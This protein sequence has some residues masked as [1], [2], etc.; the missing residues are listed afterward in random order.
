MVL[1][2]VVFEC[3]EYLWNVSYYR[4]EEPDIEWESPRRARKRGE[5]LRRVSRARS[6]RPRR[7]TPEVVSGSTKSSL[8]LPRY[9]YVVGTENS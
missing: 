7:L 9:V 5:R 8:S 6:L 2:K 4:D 1:P 3:R